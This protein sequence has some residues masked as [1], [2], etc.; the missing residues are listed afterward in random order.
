VRRG[1]ATRPLHVTAAGL[2]LEHAASL[3]AAMVGPHRLP[4]A[5]RRVDRV[6]NRRAAVASRR[7]ESSTSMTR[8]CGLTARYT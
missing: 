7:A 2:S 8:P 3:V 6:K 5:L 4:D 1:V